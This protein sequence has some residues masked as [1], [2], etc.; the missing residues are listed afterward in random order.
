METINLNQ[1]TRGGSGIYL[2]GEAPFSGFAIETFPDGKLKTQMSLMSGR[3]DGVTRRWHSNGQLESEKGFRDGKPH[4]RHREW[5][6]DGTLKQEPSWNAGACIHSSRRDGVVSNPRS[7]A[8]D[9]CV[10]HYEYDIE[11]RQTSLRIEQVHPTHDYPTL[12]TYA[13]SAPSRRQPM[14]RMLGRES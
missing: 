6:V 7:T 14:I 3:L 10:M 1:L 4:G 13:D 2:L 9:A 5:P 12:A 11:G 8:S